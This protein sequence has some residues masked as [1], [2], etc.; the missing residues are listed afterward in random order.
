MENR[1]VQDIDQRT[2]DTITR[3]GSSVMKQPGQN[4]RGV[5]LDYKVSSSLMA[6]MYGDNEVSGE[7]ILINE[8]ANAFDSLGNT[9]S[10]FGI[11]SAYNEI[12][13]SNEVLIEQ[14]KKSSE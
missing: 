13:A 7:H 11:T 6:S 10:Q 12:A 5:Q 8:N 2:S 14:N 4:G 9:K 1:K 3:R